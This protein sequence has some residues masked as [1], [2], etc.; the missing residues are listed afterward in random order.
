VDLREI[1]AICGRL[2]LE[3]DAGG[4]SA[5]VKNNARALQGAL[6][7]LNGAITAVIQQ[8]C[9]R[10]QAG[11]ERTTDSII[12]LLVLCQ[13]TYIAT[14]NLDDDTPVPL[15]EVKIS[16]DSGIL[17]GLGA[18]GDFKNVY[19]SINEV[20][21]EFIDANKDLPALFGIGKLTR[22]IAVNANDRS[23]TIK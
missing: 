4:S 15:D 23:W 5:S 16:I 22:I 17:S 14:R 1:E 8:L 11:H 12:A 2:D 18:H 21:K 7:G 20:V 19:D 10:M 13:L 9:V 3:P 6:T